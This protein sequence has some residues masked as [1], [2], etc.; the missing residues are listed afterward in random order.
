M[1]RYIT[2]II[3]L[4]TILVVFFVPFG[5]HIDLGPGPNSIVSMI[6][7]VPMTPAWYS[8]R[9]FSAFLYYFDYIFFRLIFVVYIIRLI[10]GKFNKKQFI[11][12]GLISELIPLVMAIVSTFILNEHG[13]NLHPIIYPIPIL[14]IFDLIIVY[15]SNQLG[16]FKTSNEINN[17]NKLIENMKSGL[18]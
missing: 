5:I 13:D 12:I 17:K 11:L 7:E 14:M 9:F 15:L 8:I 16:L 10:I 4:F 18:I 6:W 2:I 3:G 1:K